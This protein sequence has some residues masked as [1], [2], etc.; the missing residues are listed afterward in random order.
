M[1]MRLFDPACTPMLAVEYRPYS[2]KRKRLH[3]E[4]G[5][6]RRLNAFG[7]AVSQLLIIRL[8]AQIHGEDEGLT[9]TRH[10]STIFETYIGAI[11]S[12]ISQD[13]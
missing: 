6:L 5:R 7:C 12:W 10:W 2:P 9:R 11:A 8:R 4:S 3:R 1:A 13:R